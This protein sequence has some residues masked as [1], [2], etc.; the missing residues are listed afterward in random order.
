MR[1]PIGRLAAILVATT[2]FAGACTSTPAEPPTPMPPPATNTTAPTVTRP[3]STSTPV[4]TPSATPYPVFWDDF[5]GEFLEGWTWIRENDA[6]WSLSSKP[7][8]LRIVLDS[9]RPPRNL[10]VREVGSPNFQIMT[11]VLFEPTSNYQF[12]GLLVYQDDNTIASFGR[13]YCNNPGTCVG[14]GTYFDAT[15]N[16]QFQG[17][18]FGTDTQLKDEAYLRVDKNGYS[19]KAYYSEDGNNWMFIGEHVVTML[20]PNSG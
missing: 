4:P 8:Y 13:A 12:A 6:L 11:H 9:A 17:N 1:T 7:G 16:G 20:D 14:N 18:N 19:F 5:D 15:E 2:L 10:L 3:P